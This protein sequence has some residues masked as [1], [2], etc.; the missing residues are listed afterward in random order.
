MRREAEQKKGKDWTH[1]GEKGCLEV[2]DTASSV[3]IRRD[4]PAPSP[5]HLLGTS[6]VLPLLISTDPPKSGESMP[7]QPAYWE[8]LEDL[9]TRQGPRASFTK[10][11]ILRIHYGCY[12]ELR[13]RCAAI[14]RLWHHPWCLFLRTSVHSVRKSYWQKHAPWPSLPLEGLGVMA[15]SGWAEEEKP[16]SGNK[17]RI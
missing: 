9:V 6:C 5:T 3:W 11:S 1:L 12:E 15:G 14:T 4:G 8:H 16:H 2:V 13:V 10:H 17:F 7:V